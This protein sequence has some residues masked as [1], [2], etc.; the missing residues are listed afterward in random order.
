MAD[1]QGGEPHHIT[2]KIDI[3]KHFRAGH[4]FE[5]LSKRLKIKL[6][7]ILNAFLFLSSNR[8]EFD[9]FHPVSSEP[10]PILVAKKDQIVLPR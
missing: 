7:Y 5:Y 2:L 9:V 4:L 3:F 8:E 1:I 6:S 10:N